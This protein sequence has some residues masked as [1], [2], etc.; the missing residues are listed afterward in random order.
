MQ[1]P[2]R[3]RVLRPG[4][5]LEGD[6]TLLRRRPCACRSG[7]RPRRREPRPPR[8]AAGARASR[9][10]HR[11]DHVAALHRLE[12]IAPALERRRARD[13]AR[14]VELAVERPLREPREVLLRQVVAAVR[15]E[16]RASALRTAAAGRARPSR[17]RARAR[18]GRTSRPSRAAPSPCS[19]VE[20]RADD[21]EDE[22]DRPRPVCVAPNRVACS[23]FRSSRSIARISDAPAMRA[24]WI[25]DSPT[26]PQPITADARALPDLRR[27]E[28]RHDAGRDRAADQARLLDGQLARHLHRGDRRHDRV[29]RE[30]AGAQHGRQHAAV[31]AEQAARPQRAAFCT[32][33]A[34]RA[35][36]WSTRRRR[37]SSRARRGRRA[38]ARR[39]R[40]R[41]PR[42]CRRP[43]GRAGPGSGWPQPSSSIT[44]RSLWQT[45]VA[46]MRTST[47]PG[48]G[49]VD[50]DLLER[51]A[52][53][54][55]E[56]YT[57]V[58]HDRSR[59]RI[60]CATGER[61]REVDLGH[62]VLD[63]LLHPAL[64]ADR[65]RVG[66]RAAEQHGVGAERHRLQHVGGRCGCRRPSA[67]PRRAAR[68]APRRAR[69]AR[70]RR[71]R[72]G[73]RRGSRR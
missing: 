65:E 7:R 25:T 4:V 50:L 19:T 42:S 47:S 60:E 1:R 64:P 62:Q 53:E 29:R 55:A 59:S 9:Q 71:R 49:V 70:R 45:P 13:H 11:A 39:R 16:D 68:R 35:G 17:R 31:R 41:P 22:V 40:R 73:G 5:E 56:D 66:V 34:R 26:A 54:R 3:A 10:Q 46:S 32:A 61:E 51:D 27:L 21:V 63:Q 36:T 18:S 69:R 12:R 15:D 2:G 20:R 24:P 57:L 14:E 44:C 30:R 28:H 8:S 33:A 67:R 72:P 58:S 43:R 38:R 6:A 48:P 52:S 37:S 23:S